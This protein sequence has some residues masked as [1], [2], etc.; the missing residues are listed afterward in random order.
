MVK[1]RLM[2]CPF[3]CFSSLLVSFSFQELTLK[4]YLIPFIITGGLYASYRYS[5]RYDSRHHVGGLR[6]CGAGFFQ[7][8]TLDSM[9]LTVFRMFCAS[10]IMLL[11]TIVKG[12]LKDSWRK[13]GQQPSL[14]W[15][16]IFYGIVGLMLMHYT[17]FASIAAGNAAA[18]TVIQYTCPAMVILWVSLQKRRLPLT[19]ELTAVILAIIGVILLVTG[20][21]VSRLSVPADCVYLGLASAVFFAICCVFPKRFIGVLDNSFVL[22]LGMFTGAVAS[23]II[24]PMGDFSGFFAPEVASIFSGSSSLVRRYLLP[25]TMQA[26]GSFRPH[27][28]PSLR[29]LSRRS[30]SLRLISS[31]IPISILSRALAFC[32]FS[33]LL[34]CRVLLKMKIRQENDQRI[35]SGCHFCAIPE[36]D[37]LK[38]P[39][40][41]P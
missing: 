31:F 41:F 39:L 22:A 14:W 16:L 15:G 29:P 3:S 8:S 24:N 33:W 6:A 2:E 9:D 10:G 38:S 7:K 28:L 5:S 20:G 23:Y 26:F 1:E 18:A 34:Q 32:S 30:L 17:Y 27:R 13:L 19:G 37:G 36:R 35:G 4:A 11:V 12:Q 21:D 25:A 40:L